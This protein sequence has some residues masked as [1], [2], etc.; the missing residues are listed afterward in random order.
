MFFKSEAQLKNIRFDK[1][2]NV[3]TKVIPNNK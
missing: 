3:S 2:D 1:F